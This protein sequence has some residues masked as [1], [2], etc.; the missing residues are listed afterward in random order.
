MLLS[1]KLLPMTVWAAAARALY[2]VKAVFLPYPLRLEAAIAVTLRQP[3][4]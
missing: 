4:G 1:P 2:S 3:M